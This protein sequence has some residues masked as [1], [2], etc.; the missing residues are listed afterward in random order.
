MTKLTLALRG[1]E[2][3]MISI[4]PL[5]NLLSKSGAIQLSFITLLHILLFSSTLSA[6]PLG[7]HINVSGKSVISV[8]PDQAQINFNV[9]TQAVNSSAAKAELD[10]IINSFFDELNEMDIED[11]AITAQSMNISAQYDYQNRQQRFIGFQASRSVVIELSDL[12]KIHPVLDLAV[13]MQI[14]G[15]QGVYY[16]SSKEEELQQQ[17]R[18]EAIEDSIRKATE[19]AEAYGARLGRVESISYQSVGIAPPTPYMAQQSRAVF[20]ESAAAAGGRFL[21]DEITVTDEIMVSFSLMH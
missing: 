12:E 1:N 9:S 16:S 7:P 3:M 6:Q 5:P 18:A 19:I 21:P 10:K 11:D 17:A 13:S 20:T 14:N 2:T 15:I 4:N 8:K